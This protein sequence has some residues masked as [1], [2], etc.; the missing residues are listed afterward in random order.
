MYSLQSFVMN[1]CS[2][3]TNRS[4]Y[5]KSWAPPGK[6]ERQQPTN[7][8]NQQPTT[9]NQHPTTINQ[10]PPPATATPD[11]RDTRQLITINKH[12][13]QTRPTISFNTRKPT[14]NNRHKKKLRKYRLEAKT[15]LLGLH[16]T[17]FLQTEVVKV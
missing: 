15:L 10:Q 11:N 2:D 14:P 5:K 8:R 7:T 6:Y 1:Y 9:E 3:R 13:R 16:F 17:I 4:R 12:H